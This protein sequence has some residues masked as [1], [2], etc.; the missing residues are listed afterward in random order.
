MH[1]LFHGRRIYGWFYFIYKVTYFLG[2]F[3]YLVILGVFL[4]FN[5]LLGIQADT[6]LNVGFLAVFYA[7]YYGVLARDIAE[8][9]ANR[10][11][12]KLGVRRTHYRCL[13]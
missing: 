12:S 4:G 6:A 13:S 11:A 5:V 10:L 2:I 1:L 3:G 9:C 8:I 7:M